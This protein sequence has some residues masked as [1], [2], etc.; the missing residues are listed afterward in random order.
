MG[1]M[2]GQNMKFQ[3]I[4][5]FVCQNKIKLSKSVRSN[6]KKLSTLA[7][8]ISVLLRPELNAIWS[9][10]ESQKWKVYK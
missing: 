7:N 1:S 8:F 6:Q 5:N 10:N 3:I 2:C 9:C 4:E